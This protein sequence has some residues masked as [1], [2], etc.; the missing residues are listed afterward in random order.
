MSHTKQTV[1][2][3]PKK[4]AAPRLVGVYIYEKSQKVAIKIIFRE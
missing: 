3:S 1:L 4:H 2:R